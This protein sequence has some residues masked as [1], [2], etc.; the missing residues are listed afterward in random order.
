YFASFYAHALLWTG[1]GRKATR[2]LYAFANHASQT[3]V[4]RE[5]QKPLGEGLEMVGDMPHN[6]ASAEFIRLVRH[7]LVIERAGELHLFE[8]LPAEW[9]APGL[10]TRLD[11]VATEFGKVSLELV[12]AQDGRSA[13][14]TFD[15]PGRTPPDRVALHLDG[16][17]GREGVLEL[18]ASGR[19]TLK[20]ELAR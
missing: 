20:I 2:T 8:G 15:P 17:S 9:A 6:W 16:W 14:L 4:W 10:V 12:V 13:L 18:A 7:L 1:N 19:Q 5:E 11:G 3:L